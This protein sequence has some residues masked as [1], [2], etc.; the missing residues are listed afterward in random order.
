[1]ARK[2]IGDFVRVEMKV[3]RQFSNP[4]V[5]QHLFN[6]L[7]IDRQVRA[8]PYPRLDLLRERS[9]LQMIYQALQTAE[10]CVSQGFRDK[11]RNGSAFSLIQSTR[12]P[13]RRLSINPMCSSFA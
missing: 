11:R 9:V 8:W 5:A 3:G 6:L 13:A 1:V 10:L 7:S 12:K 2:Q 4:L